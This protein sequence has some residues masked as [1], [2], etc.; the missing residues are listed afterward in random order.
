MP[1]VDNSAVGALVER[2]R[3][4]VDSGLLPAAQFALAFEGEVVVSEALGDCTAATRFHTY[5]AVKPT[6]AL[7]AMELAAEGLFDISAPVSDVLPS[8]GANG[9]DAITVSQVLLHAGGFPYAPLGRTETTDRAARL[10][11]YAG[12]RT[13]W[14]PGSR[15][16]YH[17]LSAHWVAGDIITEVTGR[18]YA[19]VI[20]ERVMEPAGCSCWLGIGVEEQADVADVVPVG[21]VPTAEE[22][23]ALGFEELPGGIGEE[24]LMVFNRPWVRAA[25]IP[26]GGGIA[27]AEEM[28]RWY[29]AV[30][31][32]PDGFLHAE[33]R[34]DAMVVRQNHPDWTRTPASRSHAFVLAGDDGKAAMRGHG[35]GASSGAFGHSGAG[36][37][38]AWADPAS[39]ISFAYLTNGLDRND[40]A[41]ARRRVALSTRALACGK[42]Q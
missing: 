3:R 8:F 5:S 20:V 7:T 37:Q 23:A 13:D 4:D 27:R 30:L 25:G 26:G 2:A 22:L 38:A 6:V 1:K 18:S 10:A 31:H 32:N 19:D 9:K 40:L 35:H 21:S 33:V 14:Q 11:A 15:Y 17:P 42:K 34:T 29:Q 39:G 36:G 12:W 16:E 28:A 24:A 41:S